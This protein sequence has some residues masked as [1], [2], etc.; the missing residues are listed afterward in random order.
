MQFKLLLETPRPRG[1]LLSAGRRRPV[2]RRTLN[3]TLSET[4]D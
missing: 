2:S 4:G 3:Y 1:V